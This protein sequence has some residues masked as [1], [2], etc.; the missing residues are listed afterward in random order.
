MSVI[1]LNLVKQ[2][3]IPIEPKP[4]KIATASANVLPFDRVGTTPLTAVTL[5]FHSTDHPMVSQNLNYPFEVLPVRTSTADYDFIIGCDLIRLLFPH[6]IPSCFLPPSTLPA[7]TIL[8]SNPIIDHVISPTTDSNDVITVSHLTILEELQS[9]SDSQHQATIDEGIGDIP[10][11]EL[12]EISEPDE[13]VT[14]K[15]YKV[16][17]LLA[18]DDTK[19]FEL[20]PLN[21]RFNNPLTVAPKKAKNDAI[22]GFRICFDACALQT[23]LTTDENFQTQV[24][25]MFTVEKI[26]KHRGSPGYFE[27]LVN[28]TYYHYTI[29]QNKLTF[30]G[31]ILYPFYYIFS[32]VGGMLWIFTTLPFGQLLLYIKYFNYFINHVL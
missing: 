21:C 31:Y 26:L 6:T 13:L 23:A 30:I 18:V 5:F 22:I 8:S 24:N 15:Q 7:G 14:R 19:K 10:C 1:D 2:H 29:V 27:Y 28:W 16:E 20:V 25:N 32:L 17:H 11:V 12:P 3:K 4:G 9:S